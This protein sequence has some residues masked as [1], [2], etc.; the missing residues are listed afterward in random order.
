MVFAN[1]HKGDPYHT[2]QHI[3]QASR[4]LYDGSPPDP[5]NRR[6]LVPFQR[7]F[8]RRTFVESWK[9]VAPN[10]DPP[11][12]PS[13]FMKPHP[14]TASSIPTKRTVNFVFDSDEG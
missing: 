6:R 5:R 1:D 8:R 2:C 12:T 4:L 9:K 11:Q 7:K 14:S 3:I 10:I 13:S